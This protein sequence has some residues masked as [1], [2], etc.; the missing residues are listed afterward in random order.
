MR[1]LA[2]L[3]LAAFAGGRGATVHAQAPRR[4]DVGAFLAW[5]AFDQS[6]K[7]DGL[8]RLLLYQP[9]H[10]TA[11]AVSLSAMLVVVRARDNGS[12]GVNVL[13]GFLLAVVTLVVVPLL[14]LSPS[15]VCYRFL[16]AGSVAERKAVTDS[17]LWPAVEAIAS[18]ADPRSSSAVRC[19]WIGE[20][21]ATPD[22]GG[23]FVGYRVRGTKDADSD[24]YEAIFHLRYGD[25]GW[26]IADLAT[27]DP[28][29]FF[30]KL[31]FPRFSH[32]SPLA[33]GRR[34]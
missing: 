16:N 12:V 7:I 19:E 21:T 5:T 8:H 3:A 24:L 13:A 34:V 18:R 2:I 14:P 6:L 30:E 20:E 17:H 29:P 32:K 9:Q 28:T 22:I 33:T 4:P 31:H 26:K 11:W 15:Q 1:V 25:Q 10:A 27:K 23:Y